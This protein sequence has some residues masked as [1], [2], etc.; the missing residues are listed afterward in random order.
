MPSLRLREDEREDRVVGRRLRIEGE[1]R[2]DL[3]ER[4][5]QFSGR[6]CSRFTSVAAVEQ[7]PRVS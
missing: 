3:L 4:E 7:P 5:L 1:R 6:P 2:R